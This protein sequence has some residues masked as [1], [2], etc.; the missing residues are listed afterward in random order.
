MVQGL[1]ELVNGRRSFEIL[2]EN[3][4]LLL[5][6]NVV[7]ALDKGMRSLLGWMSSPRLMTGEPQV[8]RVVDNSGAPGVQLVD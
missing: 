2:I 7:G 5:Q 1:G 6:P 4:P 8:V 3:S